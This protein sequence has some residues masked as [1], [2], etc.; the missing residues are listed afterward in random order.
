MN[1]ISECAAG[2]LAKTA[3]SGSWVQKYLS[4][5]HSQVGTVM[6]YL[7]SAEDATAHLTDMSIA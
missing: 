3:T 7:L 1:G 2:V 6:Q 5:I 4:V